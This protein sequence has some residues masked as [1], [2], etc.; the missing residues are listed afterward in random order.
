MTNDVVTSSLAQ[1]EMLF[2]NSQSNEKDSIDTSPSNTLNI[3]SAIPII[4]YA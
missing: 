4:L 3:P 1:F 2:S